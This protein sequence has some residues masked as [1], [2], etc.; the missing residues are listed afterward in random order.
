M[1]IKFVPP[2]IGTRLLFTNKYRLGKFIEIMLNILFNVFSMEE[3][4]STG[5]D[6]KNGR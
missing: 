3:L 2:T 1:K 4:E 6:I 5:G